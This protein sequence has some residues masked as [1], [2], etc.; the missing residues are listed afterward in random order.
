MPKTGNG[1][2]RGELVIAVTLTEVPGKGWVADAAEIRSVAQG[3]TAPEAV[4]NLQELVRTHPEMLD[5]IETADERR[6]ELVAV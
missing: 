5:E 1:N 4:E 2:G 3:D 6:I